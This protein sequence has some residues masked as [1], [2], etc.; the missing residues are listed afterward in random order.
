VITSS[1]CKKFIL[2]ISKFKIPV[3]FYNQSAPDDGATVIIPFQT[4][5]VHWLSLS[6]EF[7]N[8][9][10]ADMT[11][12]TRELYQELLLPSPEFRK[13]PSPCEYCGRERGVKMAL[14]QLGSPP[15]CDISLPGITYTFACHKFRHACALRMAYSLAQWLNF[16]IL[17]LQY[18]KCHYSACKSWC[19]LHSLVLQPQIHATIIIWQISYCMWS[20]FGTTEPHTMDCSSSF[21]ATKAY[22]KL[23]SSTGIHHYDPAHMITI[24]MFTKGF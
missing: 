17:S 11:A 10:M 23:F 8:P 22:E 19:L 15:L 14:V 7:V 2:D 6:I 9:L 20:V 21:G 13:C 12:W 1:W 24:E 4:H 18:A 16:H 3:W 5:T